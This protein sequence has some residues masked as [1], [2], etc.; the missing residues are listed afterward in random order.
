MTMG[1]ELSYRLAHYQA[2]YRTAYQQEESVNDL[3]VAIIEAFLDGDK[4]FA[5]WC[6]DAVDKKA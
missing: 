4:A 2:F 3:A 6:R 5:R 1:P